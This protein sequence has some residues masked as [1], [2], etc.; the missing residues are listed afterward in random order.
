MVRPAGSRLRRVRGPSLAPFSKSPACPLGA[1]SGE[2]FHLWARGSVWAEGWRGGRSTVSGLTERA[3]LLAPCFGNAGV[4][5]GGPL[6]SR[7]RSVRAGV[8]VS[9]TLTLR[10]IFTLRVMLTLRYRAEEAGAAPARPSQT[11][12][13]AN[14][15]QPRPSRSL[16]IRSTGRRRRP[17]SALGGRRLRPVNQPVPKTT[18]P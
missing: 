10:L 1:A 7:A 16:P 5:C 18:P 9:L 14:P 12:A 13:V 3:V 6:S 8:D 15:P 4:S 11:E 2:R 17:R